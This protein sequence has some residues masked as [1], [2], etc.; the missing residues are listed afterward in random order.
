MILSASAPDRSA[1]RAQPRIFSSLNTTDSAKIPAFAATSGD[2][3]QAQALEGPAG[4]ALVGC[5]VAPGFEFSNPEREADR[6][7]SIA[8]TDSSGHEGVIWGGHSHLP[9]G[10]RLGRKV[11]PLRPQAPR[12]APD[13]PPSAP[14]K[15]PA[16]RP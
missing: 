11:P 8:V 13:V 4:Y 16:L 3:E 14:T 15:K 7:L 9:R 1:L 5:V 12:I 10:T 6:I 2:P